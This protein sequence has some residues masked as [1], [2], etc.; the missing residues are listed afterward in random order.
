M[1]RARDAR[2]S[3][4]PHLRPAVLRPALGVHVRSGR[5]RLAEAAREDVVREIGVAVGDR[6]ESGLRAEH[7]EPRSPYVRGNEVGTRV[8]LQRDLKEMAGVEPEYRPPVGGQVA[9]LREGRGDTFGGLDGGRIKK[10]VHLP[11]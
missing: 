7:R 4:D 6:V 10:V 1:P 11:P 9:D 8:A 5:V 3:A 2:R